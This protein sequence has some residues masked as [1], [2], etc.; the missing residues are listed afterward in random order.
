MNGIRVL[1]DTNT[2]LTVSIF[3]LGDPIRDYEDNFKNLVKNWTKENVTNVDEYQLLDID[4]VETILDAERYNYYRNYF[5]SDQ[6]VG[7]S[8]SRRMSGDS[9]G[10]EI[11]EFVIR[12]G[13]AYTEFYDSRG[14]SGQIRE[15][16]SEDLQARARALLS[17]QYN[18]D[19]LQLYNY[20]SLE[21]MSD[22]TEHGYSTS[23]KGLNI[24]SLFP[25]SQNYIDLQ[26]NS[27]KEIGDLPMEEARD[28][29]LENLLIERITRQVAFSDVVK[30]GDKV[31][32][33]NFEHE[34]QPYTSY[35]VCSHETKKVVWD[36]FF[37]NIY[38][39]K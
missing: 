31:F 34:H 38:D 21:T 15:I 33:I 17:R 7:S 10:N 9:K 8:V 6:P 24:T 16:L 22:T 18:I 25:F 20:N 37:R 13:Y 35:V 19:T 39:K 1:C 2:L 36:L 26:I 29:V 14:L 12:P 27:S 28:F 4:F 32:A 11:Y 5:S 23:F 30:F 3:E